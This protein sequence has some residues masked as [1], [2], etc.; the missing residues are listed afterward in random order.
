MKL[1]LKSK[2]YSKSTLVCDILDVYNHPSDP[3]R[4]I[5]TI[6]TAGRMRDIIAFT[7]VVSQAE[8]IIIV[9]GKKSLL[10]RSVRVHSI[11]KD[12][13]RQTTLDI[14]MNNCIEV[15]TSQLSELKPKILRS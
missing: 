5:L 7:I 11:I 14:T 2:D 12:E 13:A 3:Q 1:I 4:F 15:K 8:K 10:S 6:P 9:A